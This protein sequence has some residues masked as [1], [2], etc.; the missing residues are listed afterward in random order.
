MSTGLVVVA[1]GGRC[2][3]SRRRVL[4]GS[5]S[6]WSPAA[7]HASAQA[8]PGPPAF[9]TM[10]IRL[11]EGSGWPASSAATSNSSPTV[12]VRITPAC[13]N[14]ASTVASDAARSA[15]VCDIAARDPAAERPLLTAITGLRAATR[16]AICPNRRGLPNDS[17]YSPITSVPSSFSQYRSRS[18]P[19]RSALFPVDTKDDKPRPRRAASVI[20]AMPKAPLWDA[21]ATPPAG[22]ATGAK[23]ALSATSPAVLSTPRQF[24]PTSRMPLARQTSSSSAWRA[25][26]RAPTSANPAERTTSARTPAAPHSRAT[27]TTAAAGTATT[28]SSTGSGTAAIERYAGR[29]PT[30]SSRGW[31]TDRRP[32]YPAVRRLL[33]TAAPTDPSRLDT[34]MT[35]TEA[36]RSTCATAAVAAI[37]SRSSNRARA[38]SPSAAGN[39]T[40]SSPGSD[41][42]STANPELRNT[43]IIRWL[44]GSTT[45]SKVT[46][47]SALASSDRWASRTVEIPRP[48]Q[49]SATSN[50]TS[51]RSG[52]S[53]I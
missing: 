33:S 42:T 39:V 43:W 41:R 2:W 45:A 52:D 16:R 13:R 14:S 34:P 19:E 47:P 11:P 21:K 35:A 10:P 28:A 25:R 29:P 9:V 22:G 32:R 44:S 24:G 15:P 7:S 30:T 38:S 37:W 48:C 6:T 51:A 4:A 8:I 27:W 31:T 1:S 53:R 23:V 20:A 46:I 12:P 40:R 36:G 26:P 18:L 3:A 49:S 5:G 50:A 17:R